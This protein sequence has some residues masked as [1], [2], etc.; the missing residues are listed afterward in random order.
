MNISAVVW[1]G[2]CNIWGMKVLPNLASEEYSG[3]P[4]RLALS[5]SG[6]LLTKGGQ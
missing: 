6:Q 5:N 3:L 4:A 1:H 2:A